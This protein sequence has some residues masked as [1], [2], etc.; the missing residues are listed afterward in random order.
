MRE[1]C[2]AQGEAI[3]REKGGKMTRL[4]IPLF[5]SGVTLEPLPLLH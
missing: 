1:S 3:F 5:G 2:T 4:I